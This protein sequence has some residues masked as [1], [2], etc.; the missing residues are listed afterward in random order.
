MHDL[1]KQCCRDFDGKPSLAD[2]RRA[3]ESEQTHILAP[4]QVRN[5]VDLILTS[6]ERSRWNR[7]VVRQQ[8]K[9]DPLSIRGFL[10]ETAM[11]VNLLTS[12]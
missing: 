1:G 12:D 3:S 2:P 10:S 6:Y 9:V 7:Q 11:F 5:G 4:K 8:G